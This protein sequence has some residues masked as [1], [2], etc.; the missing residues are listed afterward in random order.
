MQ[1]RSVSV[2][3]RLSVRHLLAGALLLGLGTADL[4]AQEYPTQAEIAVNYQRAMVT[5]QELTSELARLDRDIAS[6]AYSQA[7]RESRR[8]TADAIRARLTE[9][10]L[11]P[12]DM[13][14]VSVIGHGPYSRDYQVSPL[15]T[16]TL[17]SGAEV[18]VARWLRSELDDSLATVL[19]VY[20]N[21]PVV[22]AT[23]SIRLQLSG[24]INRNGFFIA[25]ATQLLSSLLMESGGGPARN[26][27]YAK[28]QI[29]RGTDMVVVSG[30]EFD[31]ALKEGRSLD[32]LNIQAGDEVRIA[33][34]PSGN[35]FYKVV[36][37]ASA[38]GSILF[39]VDRFF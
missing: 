4:G 27:N 21:K 20:I 36:G 5:R 13:I 25:P 32:A 11:Q 30:E 35:L 19:S 17:P 24:A 33:E 7:L 9:G 31:A 29:R 28:S 6:T 12:G 37:I 16:I 38:L 14:R 18:S 2:G 8:A 23:A 3:N 1:L 15:R 10:D 26:A 39:V 34:K 22:N